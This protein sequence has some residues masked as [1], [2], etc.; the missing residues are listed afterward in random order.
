MKKNERRSAVEFRRQR[1]SLFSYFSSTF[2][3]K[4]QHAKMACFGVAYSA[5]L[6][7]YSNESEKKVEWKKWVAKVP[8]STRFLTVSKE[9]AS[10]LSRKRIHWE[11]MAVH[12]VTRR[13]E[14]LRSRT[15]LCGCSQAQALCLAMPL[16]SGAVVRLQSLTWSQ[17]C[18]QLGRQPSG[19]LALVAKGLFHLLGGGLRYWT[20]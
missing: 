2:N 9:N 7:L 19:L 8:F 17:A 5:P 12:R 13:A 1:I 10:N 16:L 3:S 18:P 20:K 4:A 15:K 11:D 14:E 6:Q